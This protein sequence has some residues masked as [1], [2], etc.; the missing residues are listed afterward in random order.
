MNYDELKKRIATR[1]DMTLNIVHLTKST[2]TEN[3]DDVLIKILKDK[4]L[5]GSTTKSGF[6]VGNRKAV[7]F[8]DTPLYSLTQNVYYEQKII[9]ENKDR[10]QRYY[11]AGLMFKK[12]YIYRKGGRP[13]IYDKTE[14]AK[15][16]LPPTEYWRIVNLD[17]L[18]KNSIVDWTHER[19]WRVPDDL[20]FELS[21]VKL[22]LPRDEFLKKFSIKCKKAGINIYD[23][24]KSIICLSDLFF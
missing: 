19:E 9:E 22:I 24:V 21:E 13:V 2:E 23:E 15:L 8:Q 10:K 5:K 16:Y 7:C 11:G 1:N 20:E 18:N 14:E 6:I 17:L 3:L 12:Q 4:K